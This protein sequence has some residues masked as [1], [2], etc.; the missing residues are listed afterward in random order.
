[1]TIDKS[2]DVT[3]YATITRSGLTVNRFTGKYTGTVTIT[4]ASGQTLDAPLQLR[5]Q[6]LTAGVTLDN[7]TGL[8]NGV[9][10]LALP[11]ALAPGQSITLTT[12]FSNPSK[13]G[14]GYTPLLFSVK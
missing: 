10:Y 2:V 3:A 14:I 7:A 8:Q 1:V 12:T 13:T 6:S 9:P 11:S 5:L 4:N